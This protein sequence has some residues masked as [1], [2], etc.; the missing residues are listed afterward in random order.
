MTLLDLYYAAVDV[1]W[2]SIVLVGSLIIFVGMVR[3]ALEAARGVGSIGRVARRIGTDAAL[4]LEF[5]V[6]A[7]ILNLILNPTWTAVA[8]TA[9]AVAP[10]LAGREQTELVVALTVLLSVLL[11][12]VTA[13]PLSA[14]YVR[15]VEEM[16]AD[17]PEKREA[18]E[19]LESP[20]ERRR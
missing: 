13:A 15:R 8:M 4:G 5:F 20:L 17:V 10:L 14:K 6:G 16:A 7:T 2:L 1:M 12:G 3:A 9:V 11:H 18:V 19:S